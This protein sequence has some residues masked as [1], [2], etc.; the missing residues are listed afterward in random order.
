M[1]RR[2]VL[3]TEASRVVA[4]LFGLALAGPSCSDTTTITPIPHAKGCEVEADCDKG[5]TC[6][7]R[8]NALG[9]LCHVDCTSSEKCA[10]GERCVHSDTE[11]NVC[12]FASEAD[13]TYDS[14][15]FVPLKCGPD[16]QCR[17]ECKNDYDCIK[18]QLCTNQHFCAEPYE[19]DGDKNLIVGNGVN[20]GG[21][22]GVTSMPAV[23][24]SGGGSGSGGISGGATAGGVGGKTQTNAAGAGIA[25][26]GGGAAAGEGGG[27]T[28]ETVPLPCGMD[29]DCQAVGQ[30]CGTE[31]PE[32]CGACK[33]DADCTSSGAY[34]AG[35][36]C[37]DGA[38]HSGTCHP[39]GD[40]CPIGQSCDA[41]ANAC[42]LLFSRLATS[43]NRTCG[44]AE[45]GTVWC[46][47]QAP[48]GDGTVT[49]SARPVPVKAA[50][51]PGP[52]LGAV[53][54]AVGGG[55]ACVVKGDGTVWC[56][57]AGKVGDGTSAM[58][59]LPV[60]VNDVDGSHKLAGAV[61]V[62][63]R[64]GGNVAVGFAV[65]YAACALLADG[66]PRCWGDSYLGDGSG[67]GSLNP[68]LVNLPNSSALD[69]SYGRL[70]FVSSDTPWCLSATGNGASGWGSAPLANVV[71]V[72]AGGSHSCARK[73]DG[74]I[75][76]W[77]A[78]DNG[79]LG[80]GTLSS[81]DSPVRVRNPAGDGWLDALSIG[82]DDLTSCAVL[83]SQKVACWGS[84]S[85]GQLGTG[86]GG[87]QALPVVIPLFD[88]VDKVVPGQGYTCALKTDGSAWC[89][90]NDDPRGRKS[91]TPLPVL[92]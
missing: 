10:A 14:D 49:D 85:M 62:A 6:T 86:T 69:G 77:G 30:L 26:A 58:R 73:F 17:D 18:P 79:Q 84:N 41:A 27:P 89:W 68:I 24:G 16:Q 37:I 90:G 29:F 83:P 81:S 15:C 25:D 92:P 8:E 20:V 31:S 87:N 42:R 65:S 72:A 12:Q 39:D 48:L 46:W 59:L 61:D 52:F 32:L 88:S 55:V 64:G 82:A 80:D 23:A 75:W 19:V 76:C 35:T 33:A 67:A 36:L 71:E 9:G 50:A 45:S 53:K 74:S 91:G 66:F 21:E 4:L 7:K 28:S 34:G 54:V 44:I 51:G 63:V 57:G 11:S 2:R 5:L 40:D 47:G 22:G 43:L 56:W 3:R 78:N 1:N 60:Q 13:C 70:C 38:C